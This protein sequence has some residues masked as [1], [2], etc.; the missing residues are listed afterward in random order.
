MEQTATM[1]SVQILLSSYNGER[2]IREQL[3][4]LLRQEGVKVSILVR[5]DGSRDATQAI[6]EEYACG[7][8]TLRWYTG[9]NL[10]PG[11][12]FLDLLR[13]ADPADYYAFSDQDDVWDADKLL[14][15]V[16]MLEA[17]P[18]S[19]PAMYHSNLRIVDSELN[20]CRMSHS[21]S[22]QN[23]DRYSALVD[24]LATGCTMVFNR[25]LAELVNSA[26]TREVGLH[27]IWV[28]L[29]CSLFGTVVYD[30]EAH[31]SYRQHENN[32][33][34][35]YLH[36]K[37]PKLILKRIRRLFDKSLQPRW[38]NATKLLRWYGDRLSPADREKVEEMANYRQ[39]LKN[40]FK[41]LFDRDLHGFTAER[42]FCYRIL[43]LL[44]RI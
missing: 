23:T 12:S 10:G 39:N 6:L 17:L 21:G 37:S 28:T 29:L 40:R 3:D 9:E 38:E 13:R 14:C 27:D 33:I 34:G 32:V 19:G 18:E 11:G 25:A 24:P 16:R 43:I 35:T 4:S 41:L 30:P 1:K 8:E 2:F 31:I 20:F 7:H 5:D 15:A 44:G 36:R 26:D 42:E 22:H